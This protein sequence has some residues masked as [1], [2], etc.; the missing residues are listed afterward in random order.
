[1]TSLL[2]FSEFLDGIPVPA[3]LVDVDH[4]IVAANQAACQLFLRDMVGVRFV[5]VLRHPDALA[6]IADAGGTD[7]LVRRQITLETPV[8][9]VFECTAFALNERVLFTMT[10]VSPL[11]VVQR[12]RSDFVANV[13]HELRSPLATL[14]GII[15]TLKG[16]ARDDE[17]ARAKF[18]D[19]MHLE[20]VRMTRLIGDLLSLS[21]LEAKQHEQPADPL[22]IYALITRVKDALSVRFVAKGR[23]IEVIC[24]QKVKD[25][26]GDED[27][28]IEV[29]QN[30]LE[31]ALKYSAPPNPV[32]IRIVQN[33]MAGSAEASR[34]AIEVEDF[35]EGIERHH[36]PRLTERFY[37][38][39]KGRSRE[40]GGTGLG[41]AITKHIVHRHRGLLQIN[42]E[43]GKGTTVTVQLPIWRPANK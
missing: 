12:S 21:K 3:L 35:G 11:L 8:Q 7:K 16:P 36:I 17:S 27:E 1:M 4:L 42:S 38:V 31:N 13:S 25:I 20:A 9:Q 29:F 22:D 34:I 33:P 19:I 23:E 26:V 10:D 40:I 32:T 14:S 37:R 43:R 39:D 41:L 24:T 18:L 6:C 5:R 28:L 2:N 30:L 15:E